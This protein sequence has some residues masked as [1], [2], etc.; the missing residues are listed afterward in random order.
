MLGAPATRGGLPRRHPPCPRAAAASVA[1][2]RAATAAAAAAASRPSSSRPLPA[3]P[4][5]LSTRARDAV[6]L[7]LRSPPPQRVSLDQVSAL[8]EVLDGDDG[9]GGDAAAA[10]PSPPSAALEELFAAARQSRDG[11]GGS[12]APPA[13]PAPAALLLP[14]SRLCTFSPKAFLPVTR[15]CSDECGYCAFA[16]HAGPARNR[17]SFMTLGEVLDA[18][19]AAASAGATEALFTLGDRP[20]SRWPEAAAELRLLSEL[21]GAEFASTPEYVAFLCSQLLKSKGSLLLPHANAGVTTPGETRLLRRATVSQGLMLETTASG[22]APRLR[23]AHD[24]ARS[25]SKAP[26]VRLAW[27]RDAG[28]ARV[29]TTTGLLVGIG[30]TRRERL[31][32]L[33]ALRDCH[34]GGGGGSGSG[35]A[36]GDGEGPG[37]G[38]GGGGH[39]QEIIVQPFQPK[40]GTRMGDRGRPPPAASEL[41]WTVAVARLLMGPRVGIQSPPNLSPV[42]PWLS[43]KRAPSAAAA[44]AATGGASPPP[45]S[46][47]SLLSLASPSSSFARE[48]R[49]AIAS[50][51]A[52]LR[53][54]ADDFG[55][56]SLVVF[57]FF[58]RERLLDQGGKKLTSFSLK[59]KKKTPNIKVSPLTPDYVSPEAKWPH[60]DL[61]SEA[62]ALEGMILAPRLAVYPR[63]LSGEWLSD[64]K[65]SALESAK[66]SPSPSSALAAPTLASSPLGAARRLSDASGLSKGGSWRPGGG[67]GGG[68]LPPLRGG[69][70]SRLVVASGEEDDDEEEKESEGSGGVVLPLSPSSESPPSSSSASSSSASLLSSLLPSPAPRHA[71]RWGVEVSH[72]GTLLLGGGGGGARKS[73]RREEEEEEGEEESTATTAAS[74]SAPSPALLELLDSVLESYREDAK[75]TERKGGTGGKGGK[76]KPR[77]YLSETEAAILFAAR[78]ADFDAVVAAADELRYLLVGDEVTF[79][80]NRCA[81]RRAFAGGER[82]ER[83]R[84]RDTHFFHLSTDFL[85][86]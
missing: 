86:F 51:R 63:F 43:A 9:K 55:G 82:A 77:R 74:V 57:S 1:K 54:G 17:R 85:L 2:G 10:A 16:S 12:P 48:E 38:G 36:G 13:P 84:E 24:P 26:G 59:K 65:S 42:L 75:E 31:E 76:K 40:R 53:A 73:R 28:A 78:G 8:L 27:L 64:G 79:V 6:D 66:S 81:G 44:A 19:A 58:F 14:G 83:E 80:V 70:E 60:L 15:L 41:L 49:D 52:L 3:P 18:A 22:A 20:E 7:L 35:S 68:W 4:S 46:S 50:W 39:L 32:T 29:P 21:H 23:E 56:V 5:A 34:C 25:P 37:G 33:L 69:R 30:E 71:P 45:S 67:S 62:A 11:G 61:L 47:P 72:R